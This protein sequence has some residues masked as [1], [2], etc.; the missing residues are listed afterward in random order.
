MVEKAKIPE[1]TDVKEEAQFWD[2]HDLTDFIEPT[3]KTEGERDEMLTMR[4]ASDLKKQ[5]IKAANYHSIC[6]SSLARMWLTE[7]LRSAPC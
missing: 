4:V 7:K 3:P 1:F 2:A 6:P 5:L